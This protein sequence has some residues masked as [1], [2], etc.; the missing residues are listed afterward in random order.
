VVGI[1]ILERQDYLVLGLTWNQ[2]R[3]FDHK[4]HFWLL[5]LYVN[6][7]FLSPILALFKSIAFLHL[8]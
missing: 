4:L 6:P 8:G 7:F 2:I 3:D 5:K 1:Q